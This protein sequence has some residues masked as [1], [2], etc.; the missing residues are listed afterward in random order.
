MAPRVIQSSLFA[1]IGDPL[2]DEIRAIDTQALTPDRAHELVT[3]WVREL[4]RKTSE[5][6][7][8]ARTNKGS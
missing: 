7:S 2:L 8:K 3:K 4:G 6:P 1:D 5:R